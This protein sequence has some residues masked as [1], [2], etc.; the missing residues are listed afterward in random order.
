MGPYGSEI[1]KRHPS[2]KS[3]PKAFKL[4]LNFL[5][6]GPHKTLFGSF[7]IL[8][9]EILTTFSTVSLCQQRSW[10]GTLVCRASSFRVAII[11]EPNTR[12]SFKFWLFLPLGHT[13][14]RFLN[15]PP[16]KK[17][18]N[19]FIFLRIFFVFVNMGPYGSQKL[20]NAYKS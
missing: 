3:Q 8:K 17:K 12:I 19:I 14:T 5:P 1:S 4:S 16:P 9:I 13:L 15:P 11:S 10:Y 2:Y 18:K 7:E 6:S 20:Q